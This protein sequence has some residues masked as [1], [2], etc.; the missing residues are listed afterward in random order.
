M[1]IVI[2]LSFSDI[3][4]ARSNTAEIMI[5]FLEG[6]LYKEKIKHCIFMNFDMPKSIF[7]YSTIDFLNDNFKVTS[8]SEKL[9]TLFKRK[10]KVNIM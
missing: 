9:Y 3:L 1:F 7:N 8:R 4:T 2:R 10:L 5:F 6:G